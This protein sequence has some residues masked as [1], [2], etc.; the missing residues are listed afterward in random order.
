MKENELINT[1]TLPS[2]A[3]GLSE[4][5]KNFIRINYEPVQTVPEATFRMTTADVEAA[6]RKL[7]PDIEFTGGELAQWLHELGFTFWDAGEMR[8]EWLFKDCST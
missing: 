6:I 4:H 5:I 1:D 2:V 8:F 7:H 3:D